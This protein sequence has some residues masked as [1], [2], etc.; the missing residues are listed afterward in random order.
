VGEAETDSEKPKGLGS[1]RAPFVAVG[2]REVWAIRN[3]FEGRELTTA[4]GIY[5]AMN[6]MANENRGHEFKAFRSQLARRAGVTVK[7]FDR[8][9]KT[10]IEIGILEKDLLKG[11]KGNDANFWYLTY[12]DKTFEAGVEVEHPPGGKL[13]TPPGVEVEHPRSTRTTNV[14]NPSNHYEGSNR[15]GEKVQENNYVGSSKTLLPL[16][17]KDLPEGLDENFA[18]RLT[19]RPE[20]DVL[21]VFIEWH[22]LTKPSRNYISPSDARMIEKAL[23]ERDLDT[24]LAAVRGIVLWARQK[25]DG[26]TNLGRAFTTYPG[27]KP[28]GEQ[29][30]FFAGLGKKYA[31]VPVDKNIPSADPH[32]LKAKWAELQRGYDAAP[33]SIP[34]R[35]AREAEKWLLEHGVRIKRLA[36]G[37][38]VQDHTQ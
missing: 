38:P 19:K 16:D 34:G 10:F 1:R 3:V 32:M 31:H 33:E 18:S 21:K 37:Y 15:S 36:N 22:R 30:D 7:T 9:A 24:C 5:L 11:R 6:E 35:R 14:V 29:I 2:L 27:G 17:A 4:L 26:K 23:V 25:G 20:P 12:L 28:L 8:Y 13:T